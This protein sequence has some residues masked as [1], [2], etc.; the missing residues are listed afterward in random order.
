MSTGSNILC[1]KWN[2][3]QESASLVFTNLRVNAEFADVTLACEDGPG[4]EA[5]KLVLASAS[6]FFENLLRRSNHPHPLIYLRGVKGSDLS[7]LLDFIYQ[8]EAKVLQE[9]LEAFLALA[10]ELQ[11]TGLT[12]GSEQLRLEC[13]ETDTFRQNLATFESDIKVSP[14]SNSIRAT[15]SPNFSGNIQDFATRASDKKQLGDSDTNVK[16][17]LENLDEQIK[18]MMC[19]SK[20]TLQGKNWECKVCGKEGIKDATRKHI[21]AHHIAG[22]VHYCEMC[23]KASKSRNALTVHKSTNHR[24]L[25]Q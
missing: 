17:D 4:V 12:N 3:F 1:L 23:G 21:E 18:S 7:A 19:R 22:V 11:L 16:V 9:N 13:L 15:P 25:S 8:G 20:N 14:N 2:G 6:P 5:H 10:Q 24:K